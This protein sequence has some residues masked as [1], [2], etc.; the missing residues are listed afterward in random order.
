MALTSSKKATNAAFIKSFI[1][2]SLE[3]DVSPFSLACFSKPF[4]FSDNS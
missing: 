1:G 3:K 2:F 4:V